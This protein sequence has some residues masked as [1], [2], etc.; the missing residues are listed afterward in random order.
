MAYQL[1]K[2]LETGQQHLKIGKAKEDR[3]KVVVAGSAEAFF[4]KQNP[5]HSEFSSISSNLF[6]ID[7]LMLFIFF[8][9]I[10][11]DYSQ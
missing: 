2:D 8:V 9:Q 7:S 1:T 5:D 10:L 3:K 4:L 11:I 6:P